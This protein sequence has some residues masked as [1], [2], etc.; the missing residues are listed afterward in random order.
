MLVM[1]AAAATNTAASASKA[2]VDTAYTACSDGDYLIIP[3]G[4]A[5][6]TNE[7]TVNKQI[8]I[9]G[10]GTNLAGTFTKLTRAGK[11][12]HVIKNC[13]ISNIYL[14]INSYNGGGNYPIEVFTSDT[15]TNTPIYVRFD[16]LFM[17][18]G[19]YSITFNGVNAWGV[20]DHC[21][22]LNQDMSI[23]MNGGSTVWSYPRTTGTTNTLVVEDCKFYVN[24]SAAGKAGW[25]EQ[26]TFS[27]GHGIRLVV[28]NCLIDWTAYTAGNGLPYEQ[29]G[30]GEPITASPPL[31][32]NLRGPPI[33]EIYSN[34][35][36]VYT[37]YRML[38]HRGGQ[39]IVCSNVF[40]ATVSG[41]NV[42]NLTEDDMD[43][44]GY[45]GIDQIANSH[46][47]SN[48]FNG[49]PVN[50]VIQDANDV[51][52]IQLGRDYFTNAPNNTDGI[53]TWSDW[54]GSH[55]GTFAGST[56]QK[57]YPWVPLVY[58]HPVVT[59]QDG[60]ADPNIF[61]VSRGLGNDTNA[62]TLASPWATI[63]K[64]N[65]TLTNGQ[66]VY[67]LEGKYAAGVNPNNSGTSIRPIIYSNYT[68]SSVTVTGSVTGLT[69]SG[70]Q[71]ITVSG[72]SFT[73]VNKFALLS[74]ATNN[75]ITNCT[76][77]GKLADTTWGGFSIQDS[78]RSNLLINCTLSRWGLTS[79]TAEGDMIDI[80]GGTSDLSYY[81]RVEG[82][83][84][85]AAG[86]ALVNLR[87]GYNVLRGNVGH[88]EA[89]L[90][91]Y[92][93]RCFIVDTDP[94]NPGG[95]NLIESNRLSFAALSVDG[96][97]NVGIDLRT[98]FNI[99]RFNTF[100]NN[101][102]AGIMMAGGSGQVDQAIYNHIYNNTFYTNG[103]DRTFVDRT[104]SAI[105]MQVYGAPFI[106]KTN[107]IF[108]NLF[109]MHT[110]VY[111]NIGANAALNLQ[112][113]S[114]N[115]EQASD[116]KFTDVATTYTATTVGKPDLTLQATSPCI[117]AGAFLTKV[118]SA[119]S[120][121]TSFTVADPWFFQA[122]FTGVAGVSGDYVQ[123]AGQ[124]TQAKI[125]SISGSTITVDTSLTWTLN[126]GISLPYSGSAPDIGA[127]EYVGG[128]TSNN[129]RR[130]SVM[131]IL[132]TF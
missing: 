48:T 64:A 17:N 94:A 122:G 71:F 57:F 63:T 100:F 38:N 78:S 25:S 72:L 92:G 112:I 128:T 6:W 130:N 117:N 55:N 108:N 75:T 36:K 109:W 125:L 46:Y 35:F 5:T 49:V 102:D 118:T 40:T 88:N 34:T 29:H 119:S 60:Q 30:K 98:R 115:W 4:S 110:T 91:G 116:P 44:A 20:V 9:M 87:C 47:W 70:K 61:Y 12:F 84:L 85:R 22:F 120:S 96:G 52:Y 83:T 69:I 124:T 23:Q 43:S 62:G 113:R 82:C 105:G 11:L 80:G 53:I 1:P 16:H 39:N 67:I 111:Y 21:T 54:D 114:N 68:N 59:L 51:A 18:Y 10:A 14:D 79:P 73:N 76:F 50:P 106:V 28:R 99:V 19:Q 107:S 31:A 95:Y 77:L 66:T 65:T 26:E 121:G 15:N 132:R 89:W 93:H 37:T 126:Q 27:S 104:E 42:I 81:N 3:A 97:A 90:G 74:S 103:T 41:G 129:H 101:T 32:G 131:R 58:P 8:N 7:L 123:L 13:R 56:T 45:M 2:D 33:V 86:H 24:N 127:Y